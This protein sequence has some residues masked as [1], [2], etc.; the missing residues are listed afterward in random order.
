MVNPFK[1]PAVLSF[2]PGLLGLE[3]GL[4]NAIGKIN[5]TTYVEIEAWVIA[6]L[7]TGMEAGLLDPAPIWTDAKTFDASFLYGKVQGIIGGY[8]CPGESL[9][10]LRE[11]HLYKGFIWPNIRKAIAATRPVWYFF[12]NVDDHLSGTFPIVQRSLHAMGYAV[13]AGVYTAEEVGAPHQRKRLFILALA[14]P[15]KM[16]AR[17][18]IS[19][20]LEHSQ[21]HE[22][23]TWQQDGQRGGDG[24]ST[25]STELA[26]SQGGKSGQQGTGNGGKGAGRRGKK[27]D[28]GDDQ[29]LCEPEGG[30]NSAGFIQTGTDAL[31]AGL[32][33]IQDTIGQGNNGS[34]LGTDGENRSSNAKEELAYATGTGQQEQRDHGEQ[35]EQSNDRTIGPDAELGNTSGLGLQG[36]DS[37]GGKHGG[38]EDQKD[39]W[40]ETD[41]A[42]QQN[43][44]RYPAGQGLFQYDWEEKRTVEPGLGCT[45]NGYNH[46]EDLLRALGNSVVEECAELAFRELL[47]LHLK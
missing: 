23:E 19:D 13:E 42:D 9:A 22:A 26:D 43:R 5:V 47:E 18:R 41:R 46:R 25:G 11:G 15:Y 34:L 20:I 37:F 31:P 35:T 3:R 29:K 8:P 44:S 30:K 10:G 14:L 4:E 28:T 17:G 39:Q 27:L 32:S 7:L 38:S 40:S 33:T 36:H 24:F 16:A 12:E 2:C 45:I 21:T 6:N 1:S